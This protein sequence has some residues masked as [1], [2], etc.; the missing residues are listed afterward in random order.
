[1]SFRNRLA[2][3]AII[4][5]LAFLAGCGS[6]SNKAVAPP[7]GA[8]SDSSLT[9]T[10]V[11]STT[12]L[13]VN[14]SP[15][16][17]MGA[18][19]AKGDGTLGGG[20]FTLAD[21]ANGVFSNQ[22]INGGSYNVTQDGRG[23]VHLPN[24]IS[25]LGTITLDFALASTSHGV[26]S[27]FDGNGSG[28]GSLDLQGTVSQ[29]GINS[30]SYAF[31]VAGDGSS[32]LLAVVGAFTLD[33]NGAVATGVED[34]TSDNLQGA[35]AIASSVTGVSLNTSSTIAVG[36]GTAPGIAAID[37]GSLGLAFDVYAIDNTHLKVIETDGIALASGDIFLQQSTLPSGTLAFTMVGLDPTYF[38][39][40]IGGVL[41]VSSGAISGGLEDYNDGGVFNTANAVSG[42]FTALS[43]GRSLLTLTGIENGA[44]NQVLGT[45]TFAAYPST[46]GILMLEVDNAGITTG[47]ALAQTNTSFAS[48]QGY[49]AGLTATNITNLNGFFEEDDIAEFTATGSGF[50]GLIDVNDTGTLNFDKTFAG[51]YASVSSGRYS[52]TTT[53]NFGFNGAFYTVDG[54]TVL[55]LETDTNQVGVGVFGTQSTPTAGAA[56]AHFAMARPRIAA[57][58][59]SKSHSK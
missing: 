33:A 19:T 32:G 54:S 47:T 43:G 29:S 17:I 55:F 9:G 13:D 27:E 31:S 58:H 10:Y 5:S 45:Y 24:S 28:S 53:S 22:A 16:M 57:N 51:T 52:L 21:G 50:S 48:S 49:A 44:S 2:L 30:Q 20:A 1:M 15:L 25:G 36:A 35:S 39:L 34:I 4:L 59:V 3:P 8:F 37:S 23:Q 42:G 7:G 38:P 11:F 46:G 14:F 12:G 6:S 41:P 18:F 40:A 56:I 26:I